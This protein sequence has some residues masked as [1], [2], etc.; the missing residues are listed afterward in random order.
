VDLT[1]IAAMQNPGR[2]VE[3]RRDWEQEVHPGTRGIAVAALV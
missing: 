3:W 1:P 2:L